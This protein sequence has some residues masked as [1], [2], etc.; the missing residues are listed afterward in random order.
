MC[1]MDCL[2]TTTIPWYKFTKK[3]RYNSKALSP[4]GCALA[5][6]GNR[7]SQ[8]RCAGSRGVDINCGG[9]PGGHTVCASAAPTPC[10]NAV[11]SKPP[12][13]PDP[14]QSPGSAWPQPMDCNDN[15]PGPGPAFEKMLLHR[16]HLAKLVDELR[17]HWPDV[18]CERSDGCA[19]ALVLVGETV[20]KTC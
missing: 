1:E 2:S 15:H 14:A 19:W 18:R 12:L 6:D 5:R 16:G 17:Q 7:C 10:P 3:K 20:T 9:S 11:A 8:S 13:S 4:E